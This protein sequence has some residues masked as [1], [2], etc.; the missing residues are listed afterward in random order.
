[1]QIVALQAEGIREWHL[2]NFLQLEMASSQSGL[3]VFFSEDEVFWTNMEQYSVTQLHARM[4]VLNLSQH[5]SSSLWCLII[6]LSHFVSIQ[7]AA[8]LA[9]K[10]KLSAFYPGIDAHSAEFHSA[11]KQFTDLY[12]NNFPNLE[13]FW[14]VNDF[15]RNSKHRKSSAESTWVT[16][17]MRKH[18]IKFQAQKAT[19]KTNCSFLFFVPPA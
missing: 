13:F 5:I 6:I 9:T 14:R 8:S 11:C 12:E 7:K 18:Q 19:A 10:C 16:E 1:M 3:F 15:P 17:A 4:C 2:Q